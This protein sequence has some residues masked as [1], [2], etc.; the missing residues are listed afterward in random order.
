L[1]AEMASLQEAVA[2]LYGERSSSSEQELMQ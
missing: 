2:A 1:E